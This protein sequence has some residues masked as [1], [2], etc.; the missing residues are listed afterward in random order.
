MTMIEKYLHYWFLSKAPS[1]LDSLLVE[2]P[3]GFNPNV[4]DSL[5]PAFGSIYWAA[6]LPFKGFPMADILRW[7]LCAP[8][9]IAILIAIPHC[10]RRIIRPQPEIGGAGDSHVHAFIGHLPKPIK[11]VPVVYSIPEFHY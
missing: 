7:Y 5:F 1:P 10:R 4:F 8:F 6:V 9:M 11:A 3:A 2:R